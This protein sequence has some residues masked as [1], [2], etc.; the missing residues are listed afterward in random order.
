[1]ASD[2]YEPPQSLAYNEFV[3]ELRPANGRTFTELH[4]RYGVRGN[5][6]LDWAITLRAR[7]GDNQDLI[8]R[9]G[10][11][12]RQ[13]RQVIEVADSTIVQRTF[14]P[15]KPDQPPS[16]VVLMRL[17][18]GDGRKV[19]AEYDSTMKYIRAVWNRKHGRP[20]VNDRHNE[21]LFNFA[22]QDRDPN[23]R[24]GDLSWVRN[25]LICLSTDMADAVISD[26]GAFYFP[27]TTST[28]GVLRS[29]GRMQF[30]AMGRGASEPTDGQ[31]ELPQADSRRRTKRISG[32]NVTMGSLVEKVHPGPMPDDWARWP[33][34]WDGVSAKLEHAWRHF[35]ALA[36][37]T[38]DFVREG[39]LEFETLPA[40]ERGPNWLKC[41]LRVTHPDESIA[42]M[43]GDFLHNLR[44]ALDHSLTAIDPKAGR[45]VNFPACLTEAEFDGWAP[46]WSRPGGSHGALAEIRRGQPFHAKD[47]RSPEDNV[48][49]IVARLSN[50]DKHRLLNLTPI[51]VSDDMPPE[52]K[53]KASAA[54]RSCEYL[55]HHGQPLEQQQTAL[56]IELDVPISEASVEITGTIPIA[57][58]TDSY[59]DLVALAGQ[60]HKAVANTCRDLR[61]GA[62]NGWPGDAEDCGAG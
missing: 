38:M 49:R 55:V 30:I 7:V 1:M 16:S 40:P 48:L 23:F 32:S 4:V 56:L 20:A 33:A 11:L 59:F 46:K 44:G 8:G 53:I 22:T 18:P 58:S 31:N 29:N 51:G 17:H 3:G 13:V 25:T 42:L 57:V 62:L 61:S 14:D 37:V 15:T 10:L 12:D 19:D 54:V 6:Y 27:E 39:P 21:A 26:C 45:K 50:T 9:R 24:N 47:G 35:D 28:A 2:K 43:F 52:L 60:L 5:L 41:E 36:T 34:P